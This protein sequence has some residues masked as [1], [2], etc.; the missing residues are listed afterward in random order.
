MQRVAPSDSCR[1]FGMLRNLG[2]RAGGSRRK[3]KAAQRPTQFA[4]HSPGAIDNAV[5]GTQTGFCATV[6]GS[7]WS[8]QGQRRHESERK[9][10]VFRIT[11]LPGE[12]Q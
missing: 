8:R 11:S 5:T 4:C 3:D 1:G 10:I 2:K 7:R 6:V 9:S 12:P